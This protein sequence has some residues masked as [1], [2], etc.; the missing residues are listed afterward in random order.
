MHFI[1]HVAVKTYSFTVSLLVLL[2]L[3]AMCSLLRNQTIDRVLYLAQNV[4]KRPH[5]L[6]TFQFLI[7]KTSRSHSRLDAIMW[8]HYLRASSRNFS[9]V[10]YSSSNLHVLTATSMS[11]P[12]YTDIQDHTQCY[13]AVLVCDDTSQAVDLLLLQS[14]RPW[15]VDRTTE[16]S[17]TF[18]G[19]SRYTE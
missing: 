6:N 16:L 1:L 17:V 13:T 8:R 4:R 11:T 14:A 7:C 9:A 2:N 18:C 15:V 5:W 12:L 10:S 3:L 19:V